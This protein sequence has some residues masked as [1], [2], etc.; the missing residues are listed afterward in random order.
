[1]DSSIELA[2]PDPDRRP[3]RCYVDGVCKGDVR[4]MQARASRIA[5]V[6]LAF[7]PGNDLTEKLA[8]IQFPAT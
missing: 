4:R 5:A 6:E 1:M 2:T 8:K 3:L 7:D